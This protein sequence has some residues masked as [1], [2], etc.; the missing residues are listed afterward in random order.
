MTKSQT[1]SNP[2][3]PKLLGPM[4]VT[5]FVVLLTVGA[6]DTVKRVAAIKQRLREAN[7]ERE[8]EKEE[9]ARFQRQM[10]ELLNRPPRK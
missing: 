6:C 4:I 9:D 10:D 8:A 7:A 5:A 3:L 2:R 1:G